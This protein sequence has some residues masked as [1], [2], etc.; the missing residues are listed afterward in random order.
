MQIKLFGGNQGLVGNDQQSIV[1]RWLNHPIET[2]V[3]PVRELILFYNE[4]PEPMLGQG[5]ENW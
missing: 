5:P 4:A 2:I 1:E 3:T